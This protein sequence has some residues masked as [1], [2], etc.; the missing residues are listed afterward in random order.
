MNIYPRTK[1]NYYI[2]M[3]ERIYAKRILFDF[4]SAFG[5]ISFVFNL[6]SYFALK[7]IF[8]K[9]VED[10]M[11]KDWLE[12]ILVVFCITTYLNMMLPLINTGLRSIDKKMHLIVVGSIFST[13]LLPAGIYWLTVTK[14]IQIV[15]IY[16]VMIL[17][18]SFRI[19]LNYFTLLFSDWNEFKII[20]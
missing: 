5:V 10:D 6:G 1:I 19:T 3:K 14:N 18:S 20:Y 15:G 7:A 9:Y 13:V 4:V 11:I 17:E 16:L 12:K 2:G 8:K